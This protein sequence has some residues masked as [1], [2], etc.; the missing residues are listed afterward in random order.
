[1]V[2]ISQTCVARRILIR[3]FE[4]CTFILAAE[5][6]S[7]GRSARRVLNPEY[8]GAHPAE[9]ELVDVLRRVSFPSIDHYYPGPLLY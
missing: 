5:L 6:D 2:S 8:R 7:F 3:D 1:M 9:L 4:G